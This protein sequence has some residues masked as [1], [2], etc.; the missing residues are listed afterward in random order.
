MTFVWIANIVII[1]NDFFIFKMY[2]KIILNNSLLFN[3]P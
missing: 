3:I 2:E 1:C